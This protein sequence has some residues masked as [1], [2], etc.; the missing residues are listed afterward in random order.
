MED[1][2]GDQTE[3]ERDGN[4]DISMAVTQ[5]GVV[6]PARVDFRHAD[7]RT[8]RRLHHKIIDRQFV[9]AFLRGGG[10][11]TRTRGQQ[12]IDLTIDGQ[13]E[14]RH[15]RFCRCQAARNR[16]AHRVVRNFL[17]IV[18]LEISARIRQRC[19]AGKA[20]AR[21]RRRGCSGGAWLCGSSRNPG[22]FHIRFHDAATRTGP[23][24]G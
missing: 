8:G 3:V 14:M 7:Q 21:R 24:K 23:G 12:F 9:T 13:I 11:Q 17:V 15:Q 20:C 4:A 10:I 19:N 5:D 18:R 6:G 22:A 16:L 2:G 1:D